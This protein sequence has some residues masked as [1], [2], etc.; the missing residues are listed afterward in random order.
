MFVQRPDY[1]TNYEN[2]R[3]NEKMRIWDFSKISSYDF[4]PI[5]KK[6]KKMVETLDMIGSI[7]V[8]PLWNWQDS[9]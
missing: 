6:W 8:W 7:E 9:T 5:I 2:F 3:D 4:Y 1:A